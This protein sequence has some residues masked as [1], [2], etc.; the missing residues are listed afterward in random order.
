[1]G[2]KKQIQSY[3]QVTKEKKLPFFKEPIKQFM[4]PGK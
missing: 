2:T 1:M 4:I 3:D